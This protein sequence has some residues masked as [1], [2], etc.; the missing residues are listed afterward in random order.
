M[1]MPSPAGL[2]AV[3]TLVPADDL[4]SYVVNL[5]DSVETPEDVVAA[6]LVRA[7]LTY[8]P[9]TRAVAGIAMI[10]GSISG[11][12]ATNSAQR[13][14]SGSH[15]S[16][17]KFSTARARLLH[18]F[19]TDVAISVAAR[20]ISADRPDDMLAVA[21]AAVPAHRGRRWPSEERPCT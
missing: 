13:R 3:V 20:S 21:Q 7:R 6:D 14:P 1:V 8:A 4:V 12:E 19:G 2:A 11:D 15:S 9:S 17:T 18:A 16:E 10:S 5:V